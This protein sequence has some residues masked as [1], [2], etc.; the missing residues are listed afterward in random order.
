MKT[1]LIA[2]ALALT[3]VSAYAQT[4]ADPADITFAAGRFVVAEAGRTF[5]V[6]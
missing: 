1:R 4:Q 2:C 5:E 3:P 6:P